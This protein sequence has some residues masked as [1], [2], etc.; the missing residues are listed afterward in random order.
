MKKSAFIFILLCGL[1]ELQGQQTNSYNRA[2]IDSLRNSVRSENQVT[3]FNSYLALSKFY[4]KRST[5]SSLYYAKIAVEFAVRMKNNDK[6]GDAYRN[7]GFITFRQ[8]DYESAKSNIHFAHMYYERDN[9][10]M[11]IALMN[12][13]LGEIYYQHTYLNQSLSHFLSALDVFKKQ[14]PSLRLLEITDAISRIYWDLDMLGKSLE[15]QMQSLEI[16]KA[17]SSSIGIMASKNRIA[18]ILSREGCFNEAI[19][20]FEESVRYHSDS[21]TDA[22]RDPGLLE[23]LL[24]SLNGLAE[25]YYNIGKYKLSLV[26][27]KRAFE[28]MDEETK[29]NIVAQVYHNIGMSYFGL[30]EFDKSEEFLKKA[31]AKLASNPSN[32]S[33]LSACNKG[34][35]LLYEKK[36][37]YKRAMK[38]YKI[39]TNLKD[40]IYG[41]EI[42]QKIVQLESARELEIKD[43]EYKGLMLE[44]EN[45]R[46]QFQSKIKN[47]FIVCSIIFGIVFILYTTNALRSRTL[48]AEKEMAV[49]RNKLDMLR[50]Q[51]NPHFVFN[52]INGVQNFILKSDRYEAYELLGKLSS[53]FRLMHKNSKE[54][55]ISLGDE[56]KLMRNYIELEKARFRKGFEFRLEV[57]KILEDS[58]LKI[59]SM[60]IQPVVENA[61]I[62]GLS[63]KKDKGFLSVEF[64]Y[65]SNGQNY[66]ICVVEDNGIGRE[67]ALRIKKQNKHMSLASHNTMERLEIL[68]KMGHENV[69]VSYEDLYSDGEHP[70]GTKVTLRLPITEI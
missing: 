66:V 40:S 29:P 69:D 21:I 32:V 26:C 15:F 46:L 39:L 37:D 28:I 58:K 19:K 6:I 56:L 25:V 31:Y 5:D 12:F 61:I 9:N 44:N 30:K 52:V 22:F 4:E 23:E 55:Y 20:Y 67:E 64:Q 13:E 1:V 41:K 57:P 65:K 54:T 18:S 27:S 24:V 34:L 42:N 43:K 62:H 36:G 8:K 68:K 3:K 16:N 53:L 7:L 70:R 49:A 33:I 48:L 10:T 14:G 11:A 2:F 38:H 59:P 45:Q 35:Y 47:I 51:M 63:N 17:L 60:L 50:L